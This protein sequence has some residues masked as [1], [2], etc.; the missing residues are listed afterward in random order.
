MMTGRTTMMSKLRIFKETVI[1]FLIENMIMYLKNLKKIMS[2]K[3]A[4]MMF[5]EIASLFHL[6]SQR[7]VLKFLKEEIREVEEAKD[8]GLT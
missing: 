5:R 6:K 8:N 2:L 4:K 1:D 7:E 3:N